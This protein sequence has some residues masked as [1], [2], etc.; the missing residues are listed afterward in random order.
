[1][2]VLD[3]ETTGLL[4]DR[5]SILSIGAVDL[6]EPTNQFYDECR[7]WPDAHITEEALAINGFSRE[8]VFDETKKSEAELIRDFIGWATDRP[9]DRTLAAQNVSFD[10]SF[11]EAAAK[12][13]GLESPFGKRTLDVHSLVWLHMVGRGIVPPSMNHHSALN[14]DAALAYAG[15]PPEPKPHN[16]LMGALCHAEVIARIAYTKK[17]FP[18]FSAYDIPWVTNRS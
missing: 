16:A 10:L 2:I 18:E 13:A 6:D 12:R 7:A 14:L 17:V 8:V 5:C 11:V 1:M 3:V 9:Q 15:L 4:P